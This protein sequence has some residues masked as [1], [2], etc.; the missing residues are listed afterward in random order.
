MAQGFMLCRQVGIILSSVVIARVLDLTSVGVLEMLML[1]GYLMTFFWSDALLKGFLTIRDKLP[2]EVNSGTFLLLVFLCGVLMMSLL[3]IGQSWLIPLFTDRDQLEGL[4]LFVLYQAF[5]LPVWM[6]PFLGLLRRHNLLLICAFVLLGP[7]FACWVGYQN[8]SDLN[9]ILIG[10]LSYALVGLVWVIISTRFTRKWMVSGLMKW[11]WPTTWP[12]M[13]YA[14]STAIARSFDAW[15]AARHFDES[16]F[17]IFRYGAREFPLVVALATGFSTAILPRLIHDSYL[18]ELKS[19]SARLMHICY[20]LIACLILV[21]PPMFEFFFG[22]PYREGAWIFNVCLLITLT[23]LIF[24]QTILTARGDARWLWYISIAE[25]GV[26]IILSLL[27]LKLFGLIGIVWGTLAAFVFEKIVL[28]M[29][30]WNKYKI[31]PNTLFYPA[32]WF[33]YACILVM[34]VITSKWVFGS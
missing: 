9:G 25:L 1:C 8:L 13:L 28:L 31:A 20:P 32:V 27:F 34:A 2:R 19:R 16:V 22:T 18:P 17:A 33:S 24:P 11:I 5:I 6:A 4:P 29:I 7:A 3:L 14:I 23:Q 30:I 10:L 26:N 12:L 21:S 15:L